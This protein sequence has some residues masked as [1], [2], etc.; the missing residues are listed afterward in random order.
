M[1][2][3]MP[4]MCPMC[5]ADFTVEDT[6]G[7]E[8]TI[9]ALRMDKGPKK[10]HIRLDKDI[11]NWTVKGLRCRVCDHRISAYPAMVEALYI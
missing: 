2:K 10:G 7:V 9:D 3:E 5:E 11:A 8:V 4:V 6:L 1:S